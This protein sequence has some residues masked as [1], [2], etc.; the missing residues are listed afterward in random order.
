MQ[1]MGCQLSNVAQDVAPHKACCIL[2]VVVVGRRQRRIQRHMSQREQRTI[3]VARCQSTGMQH[4]HRGIR[5]DSEFQDAGTTRETTSSSSSSATSGGGWHDA[6]WR[7]R[8]NVRGVVDTDAAHTR[9]AIRVAFCQ[10]VIL[11]ALQCR[12]VDRTTSRAP[13]LPFVLIFLL[14]HNILDR[15]TTEG[16]DIGTTIP[17]SR[18]KGEDDDQDNYYVVSTWQGHSRS[19]RV[20]D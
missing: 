1:S 20:D 8:G 2:C 9:Q 18:I 6:M 3:G 14:L 5:A 10:I 7:W 16:I 13:S 12:V 4:R 17:S 11:T 19:R 15:T